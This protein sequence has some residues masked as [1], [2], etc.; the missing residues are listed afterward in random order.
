[1]PVR[2]GLSLGGAQ[3]VA[4]LFLVSCSTSASP[5]PATPSVA[6]PSALTP[7]E[8]TQ[9]A[10]LESRPLAIPQMPSDGN[11]PDGPQSKVAPFGANSANYLAATGGM[12]YGAGPVY[13]LGG[14]EHDG[15]RNKF[16]DVTFFTDPTV[17]SVVLVRGEQLG[18]QWKVVIVG[19]WAA[20]A[21]VGTDTVSGQR[22]TLHSE[23]ALPA[24]RPL[25]KAG[26]A[27]GWGLWEVRL[28]I[29]SHDASHCVGWQIDSASG[30]EVFVTSGG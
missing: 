20:G 12:L 1:M 17:Q 4:L 6:A 7:A 11:C 13:A 27:S 3:A 5:P 16:F 10:T 24:S 2:R 26:V 28:G 30:T 15:Q 14:P 18:G 8:R 9:L 25:F 21:V 22:L 29:D 19:P 23:L